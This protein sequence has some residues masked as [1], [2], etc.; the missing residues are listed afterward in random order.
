MRWSPSYTH[1][2]DRHE[3]ISSPVGVTTEGDVSSS[4][5]KYPQFPQ[6]DPYPYRKPGDVPQM[7]PD[8]HG[9]HVGLKHLPTYRYTCASYPTLC[10]F[11]TSEH[12]F[13][14]CTAAWPNP[15]T[16]RPTD[17]QRV[18]NA[19]KLVTVTNILL[20]E[21]QA[22]AD[23]FRSHGNPLPDAVGTQPD[24]Q[25]YTPLPARRAYGMVI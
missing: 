23:P 24:P 5:Q 17:I 4:M 7:P 10:A 12:E 22:A 19:H 15:P 21:V 1:V 14:I 18:S 11:I 6:Q 20:R 9:Y 8:Y 2:E 3:L 25:R 16:E 13:L